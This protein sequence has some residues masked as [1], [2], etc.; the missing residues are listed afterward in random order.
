ME[1]TISR[2]SNILNTFCNHIQTS[3]DALKISLDRRPIPLD[4]ASSTFVQC[5]NRRVSTASVDLNM[6]E[7]MSFGTVSFEE[8]LGHCNEVY[9]KN[10]NDLFQLQQ[11]LISFGYVPPPDID[12]DE[13]E[14]EESTD[15]KTKDGLD[16]PSCNGSVSSAIKSLQEDPLLDDSLSLKSLGLSDVCL[17]TL[18]ANSKIHSPDLFT[19]ESM[20]DY[21]DKI[22]SIRSLDQISAKT[23]GV[24]KGEMEN[25]LKPS[26]DVRPFVEV[27]KD[28]YDGLP[29]YM[30]SL[31]TWEDMLAAVDKI[32]SSLRKKEKTMGNNYF[33]QDEIASLE[34]GP[35]ARTYLLLLMRMNQLVVETIDGLISYRVLLRK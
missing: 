35:K 2:F 15:V 6:L 26:E 25:D 16:F 21:G 3:C 31:T 28:D 8:L 14:E 29:S 9:K 4:S 19:R 33:H 5:L 22:Y 27:S 17:A 13:E 23:L 24:T 12:D 18:E 1:E 34:L 30:K 20:K 7:S 32:N 11:H 10:D